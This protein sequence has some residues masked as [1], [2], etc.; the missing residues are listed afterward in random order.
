MGIIIPIGNTNYVIPEQEC[1]SAVEFHH[2]HTAPYQ[3]LPT[4][5]RW[6]G[7]WARREGGGLLLASTNPRPRPERGHRGLHLGCFLARLPALGNVHFRVGKDFSVIVCSI[8]LGE[9]DC[10]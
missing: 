4:N 1:R 2:S 7:G 6:V 10:L 8:G 3:H 9:Y 5:Q